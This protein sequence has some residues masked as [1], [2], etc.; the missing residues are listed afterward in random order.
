MVQQRL[1]TS[2][3]LCLCVSCSGVNLLLAV[4]GNNP[5]SAIVQQL[6][7]GCSR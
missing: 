5:D 4:L 7:D 6:L 1:L 2:T 3:D